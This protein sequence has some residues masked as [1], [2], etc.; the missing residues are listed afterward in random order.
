MHN[1]LNRRMT[2]KILLTVFGLAGAIGAL[3]WAIFA[4]KAY[5]I[6]P[7]QLQARY[8]HTRASAPAPQVQLGAV[9]PVT[10]GT[11]AAW[12]QSLRYTSFDGALVRGRIVHPEDP[13]R[14][15]TTHPRRSVLLALHGMGRTQWRWWQ[16]EYKGRPTIESTHLLAERALQAGHVVVALD[17]R[18]HGD[19]KDP[20]RPLMASELMRNLHVWG[21]REPYERLIVDT[22]KDY[23]VLLDWVEQQPLLDAG[24]IRA[25]GYSMGAQM[26]LLLAATDTRV[27]SVAAM[28][29]PHVDCRVAVVAP[30]SVGAWLGNVEV[31]LLTADDDEYAS[32][33]DNLALFA[34]LR[35][36]AK[37]H[38]TFPGG[39]LLPPTYVEQLQPWL[40]P[41]TQ[42]S[43]TA[44]ARL[45]DQAPLQ[46]GAREIAL[47]GGCGVSPRFTGTAVALPS[48]AS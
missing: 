4:L 48:S 30:V 35:S 28:V 1:F 5:E 19:R 34:T 14:P 8:A 10:V 40:Q 44:V 18:L 22:V 3:W 37:K 11:T 23:R 27:G 29:P 21:E 39:H 17:A 2:L 20:H 38:L 42:A 12:A 36:H 16:S 15:D 43:G 33:P 24:R 31:W 32:Q 13:A 46:R 7:E 41:N 45:R 25:A 6:S 47:N 26:A 9:E